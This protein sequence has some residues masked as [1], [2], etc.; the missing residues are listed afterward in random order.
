MTSQIV[1][2]KG[3]ANNTNPAFCER[4]Q[5][6]TRAPDWPSPAQHC[7]RLDATRVYSRLKVLSSKV[8]KHHVVTGNHNEFTSF[9][10]LTLPDGNWTDPADRSLVPQK[11]SDQDSKPSGGLEQTRSGSGVTQQASVTTVIVVCNQRRSKCS[12]KED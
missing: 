12:M 7:V 10:P 8:L 5:L 3:F 2:G 4:G 9:Y 11:R 1:Q 6:R